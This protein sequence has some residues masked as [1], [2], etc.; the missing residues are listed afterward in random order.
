MDYEQT[1]LRHDDCEWYTT[2]LYKAAKKRLRGF[3][4]TDC[5]NYI[6]GPGQRVEDYLYQQDETPPDPP[7]QMGNWKEMSR[8]LSIKMR[9][10]GIPMAG[11][12]ESQIKPLPK[13]EV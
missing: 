9:K 2:C 3:T 4:C 5:E 7:G 13:D 6:P 1:T 10:N 12:K 8:E 11:F